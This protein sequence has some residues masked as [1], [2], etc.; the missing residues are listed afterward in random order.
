MTQ[1]RPKP[2]REIAKNVADR[3]NAQLAAG[4]RHVMIAGSELDVVLWALRDSGALGENAPDEGRR[5]VQAD[6]ARE[7]KRRDAEPDTHG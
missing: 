5:F 6:M 4:V 7:R 1:D 3:I 2:E